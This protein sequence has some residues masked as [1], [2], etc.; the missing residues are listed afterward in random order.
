MLERGRALQLLA[1]YHGFD[2]STDMLIETAAL[3][4]FATLVILTLYLD[5]SY[6]CHT[7]PWSRAS[8]RH[9]RPQR[10][11]WS[12]TGAIVAPHG[13]S[14]L[15]IRPRQVLL[16]LLLLL[17]RAPASS[18]CRP[19]ARFASEPFPAALFAVL[20]EPSLMLPPPS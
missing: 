11:D 19:S 15:R 20:L 16:L 10:P 3:E 7:R 13:C 14:D 17:L 9:I 8:R 12:E 18:I 5:T 2:S 4:Y 6:S 1:P